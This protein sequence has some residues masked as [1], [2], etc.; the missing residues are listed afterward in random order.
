[1]TRFLGR[2]RGFTLIELLVV[3][4]IITILMALLVP[5]VQKVREAAN[6]MSCG[7]NLHQLG[8]A[9][10]QCHDE[11]GHFPA[12]REVIL[13]PNGQRKVHSWTPRIMPFIEHKEV[14]D[15]YRFD[16]DWDE[17]ANAAGPIR[18]KIKTFLCPS[19]P[20]EGRHP[21]RGVLDYPAT[22]ER[23]WPNPWVSPQQAQFVSAGD[24]QFIGVLGHTRFVNG[25]IEHARRT[26]PRITDGSSNTMLL[27]ECAGRN[28][29]FIF[30]Q[31]VSGTWTAGPWANPNSRLQIG[32]FNPANPNSPTGPCTVNCIN[33]KEIFSFHNGGANVLMADGGVR[34]LKENIHIDVVLQLLTR[35]RGEVITAQPF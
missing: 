31:E 23:N 14:F 7:N 34:F 25:A 10:H 8:V 6:K 12:A 16:L 13:L 18:A 2:R 27:A 3:I 4:A 26:I 1:M 24:P 11:Y 9:L 35:A 19:A 15:R 33:D 5:A 30:R 32:G 29:R 22:T 21:N 28:R 17:G 20:H